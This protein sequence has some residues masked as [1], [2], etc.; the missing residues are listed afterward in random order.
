MHFR[1]SLQHSNCCSSV[2]SSYKIICPRTPHP[3]T[4][5]Q[6][7]LHTCN[8]EIANPTLPPTSLVRILYGRI[9]CGRRILFELQYGTSTVQSYKFEYN[10]TKRRGLSTVRYRS[11]VNLQP[12]KSTGTVFVRKMRTVRYPPCSID[13]KKSTERTSTFVVL[14]ARR[15]RK[16]LYSYSTSMSTVASSASVAQYYSTYKIWKSTVLV[17]HRYRTVRVSKAC[18]FA[19]TQSINAQQFLC[20]IDCISNCDDYMCIPVLC[21]S[22]LRDC[23][24]NRIFGLCRYPG[25]SYVFWVFETG[26]VLACWFRS[27]LSY[28]RKGHTLRCYLRVQCFS[29]SGLVACSHAGSSRTDLSIAI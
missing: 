14:A 9:L 3:H 29:F 8:P 19:V 1:R 10:T 20:L 15:C 7:S 27:S 13:E 22:F 25:Y 26:R 23:S 5:H 2:H 12:D 28:Y 24:N 4:F 17:A 18:V 16:L 6:A 11:L 21:G